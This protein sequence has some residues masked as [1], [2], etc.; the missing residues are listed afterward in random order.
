M[1][2][3]KLNLPDIEAKIRWQDR[4]AETRRKVRIRREQ[5]QKARKAWEKLHNELKRKLNR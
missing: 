4:L 2:P 5:E 1:T 3:H